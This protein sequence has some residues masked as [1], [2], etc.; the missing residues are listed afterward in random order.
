MAKGKYEFVILLYNF[1]PQQLLCPSVYPPVR[2]YVC[3]FTYVCMY[4]RRSD[5]TVSSLS[6]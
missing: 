2:L 4:V 3:I 1:F 5:M 6:A